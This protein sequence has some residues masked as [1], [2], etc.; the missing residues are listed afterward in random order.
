MSMATYSTS[1]IYVRLGE[2][3]LTSRES[4][5]R[6]VAGKWQPWSSVGEEI[7]ISIH[8]LAVREI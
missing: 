8:L 3:Y 7:T 4:I 6:S 5:C 2:A 1:V